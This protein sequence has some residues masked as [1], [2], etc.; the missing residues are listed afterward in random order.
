VEGAVKGGKINYREVF[1]GRNWMVSSAGG[2]V[3]LTIEG[4][5]YRVFMA[6]LD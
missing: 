6:V 3:M 2:E 4:K 1:N 5:G